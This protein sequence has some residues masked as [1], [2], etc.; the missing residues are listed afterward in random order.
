MDTTQ[1]HIER[2]RLS[3]AR[4]GAG[5]WRRWGPY[6]SERAWGTVREDYSADG[7][8]WDYFPHDHARSRAY[9]WSEDGI[10][11]VSDTGQHICMAVAL[12]NEQDP[13]LKERMFGL[14]NG[15]GNHG[16]DVKEYYFYLDGTPTHSYMKMLYKYPQASYPYGDLTRINGERTTLDPEYELF[17]A[18]R[19]A[20][21]SQRYFDVFIE[22]AKV[23]PEDILCRITSINRGPDPAPI[24]VLP[25]LWYRN[26]WSWEPGEPRPEIQATTSQGAAHTEHDA[27]GERWWYARTSDGRPLDLLFTENETNLERLYG[28]TNPAPYVKDGINDAVVDGRQERVNS[29]QGSKLAGHAHAIVPPGGTF[30]VQVRFSAEPFEQPFAGFD[31]IFEQRIA[32]ADKFYAEVHP[33]QLSEDE[34]LVQRQAFAGLLWSKQYFHY[35]VDRWLRG[36]PTQPAPPEERW[37]GRNH[38]WQH[39]NNAEIILMPDTWEYPW[40][41]SWDL[42]FHCIALAHIDSEFAK[43]QLLTLGYEWYQHGNGLYPAYEWDFGDVNPPVQAWATLRVYQIDEKLT[44]KK[45]YAFLGEMFHSLMLNYSWWLNRKDA[46]GRDIFGGGFL[47]MDNIGVFDR[48]KPLP[49]GG[50]LEQSDGTSWMAKFSLNMLAIAVELAAHD[51]IYESVAVKYFEH[52][53]YIARAM[54]RIGKAFINLWDEEDRFFYDAINL[55]GGENIPLKIHSMV[56]LVPLFAVYTYKPEDVKDLTILRDRILW[57]VSQRPGLAE[58]LESH[59]VPG[60]DD[61]RLLAVVYGDKLR[62]ILQRML[63][64]EEFLSD[65]GVRAVSAYHRDHP[66]VFEA[67]GEEFRVEYLAAE[68]NNRL[69]GGNSNWRGPIWFPVNYLIIRALEH[70][71]DYYGDTFKVECPK[72]SG[73]QLT[74]QQIARD[75]SRRLIKIFLR[76]EEHGGRRPVFGENDYFQTDPHW[77]DCIPFHE[78]FNGDTGAAVGASHQTGWTALVAALL[79]DYGGPREAVSHEPSAISYEQSAS[80]VPAAR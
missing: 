76:D 21:V 17:D 72:G 9:R 26:F 11:G 55:P 50:N 40:Y 59:L 20:F 48:D 71:G 1:E 7:N 63:D 38:A 24:H 74:L 22:Y 8:A 70:F 39:L 23:N 68:S 69:F 37:M 43:Q 58:Q 52:Y 4:T 31:A 73:Q 18:I 53:L 41:A 56:G 36:D 44:G 25:H 15:Q 79:F 65:F 19:D 34:K 46:D 67:G 64:P 27:A 5:D 33:P 57:F 2:W 12:W 14:S 6:L 51:H 60:K 42:A 35:D 80:P 13:I 32:E 16:E 77:R 62:G 45:D 78:Y 30:T 28:M 47:G 3:E 10:G 66:Y 29:Q 54:S 61:R 49:T 75:L